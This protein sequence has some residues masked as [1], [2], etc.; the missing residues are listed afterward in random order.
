[1]D[2]QCQTCVSSNI[3]RPFDDEFL[4]TRIKVAVAKRRGINRIEQL[5]QFS[6]ADF[7]HPAISRDRVSCPRACTQHGSSS[8]TRVLKQ[9]DPR[10]SSIGSRPAMASFIARISSAECPCQARYSPT[11]RS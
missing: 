6:D 5:T 8:A 3:T 9:V 10:Q 4:R 1:M 7:D 11:T 2:Q